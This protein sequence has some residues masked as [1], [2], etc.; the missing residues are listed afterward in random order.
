MQGKY[1]IIYL[2]NIAYFVRIKEENLQ[3]KIKFFSYIYNAILI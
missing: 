2:Y 1:Y 3:T